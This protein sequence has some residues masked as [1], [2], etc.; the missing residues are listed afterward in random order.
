MPEWVNGWGRKA[1]HL[2]ANINF[3][4]VVWSMRQLLRWW[5]GAIVMR[6]KETHVK[7]IG[8]LFIIYFRSKVFEYKKRSIKILVYSSV[9]DIDQMAR[10]HLF[11]G[12][13]YQRLRA[14]C[15]G[16]FTFVRFSLRFVSFSNP[17]VGF[18][19]ER[20]APPWCIC[21]F[22]K[23]KCQ[24][25]DKS[26]GG[27]GTLW[28]DWAIT[29]ATKSILKYI[30]NCFSIKWLPRK[31]HVVVVQNNG[32]NVQSC[33]LLPVSRS[34]KS[35]KISIDTCISIKKVNLIW[36]ISIVSINR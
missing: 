21:S 35:I 18:L 6:I 24:M 23:T 1:R 28:I 31:V 12:N 19:Y 26:P 29:Q 22:S 2:K 8:C 34:N 33:F 17:T 16:R 9:I 4:C 11:C 27:M 32:K 10:C 15:V 30:R 3:L 5:N 13:F 14:I 20:S 7:F 25:P 36:L